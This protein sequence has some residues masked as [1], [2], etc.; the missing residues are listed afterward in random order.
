MARRVCQVLQASAD[1]VTL[2]IDL[3]ESAGGTAANLMTDAQ[4]GALAIGY[5]A[6]VHTADRDFLRFRDVRYRFPLDD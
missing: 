4:I 2:V 5:R 6:V 3:L 1:H